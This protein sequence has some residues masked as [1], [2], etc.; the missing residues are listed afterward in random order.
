[1][2]PPWRVEEQWGTVAELHARSYALIGPDGPDP[3]T[4]RLRVLHATNRGVV[5]GSA[6]PDSDIDGP[7]A[8]AAGLEVVRRRTGGGAVLV[9]PGQV[10]WIDVIVPRGDELWTDDVGQ[11]FWWLGDLWVD[12]LDCAGRCGAQVW[13]GGLQRRVWTRLVCFAALGPG[14]VTI[15]NRKVVGMA[16]RRTRRGALFQCALPIV[17][18][19]V[20]LLDVLVLSDHQRR[21]AA[22]ELAGVAMGVGAEAASAA[23]AVLV[24][25]LP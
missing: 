13:R 5:L 7:R 1:M 15:A 8:R 3:L 18:D 23:R 16:Q 21:L 17:W 9:G 19:P 20:P 4:R 2:S 10:L 12:A 14:E 22:T 11:A 25:R 6:Q 24:D